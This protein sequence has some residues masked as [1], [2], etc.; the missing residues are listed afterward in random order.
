VRWT[1][2][3]GLYRELRPHLERAVEWIDRD[4]D[5]DGDG[6]T[7][8]ATR[9]AKGF[10]N[11]GWKDSGNSIVNRDGSLAEP[12]I[13]LVEV[14]GYVYR[15][16]RGLAGVARACGD[17]DWARRLAADAHALRQ[18]FRDAF[19][20]ADRN[21]LSLALQKDGEPATAIASN[22]GQAVWSGIVDG[23]QAHAVADRLMSDQLFS[24][25]GI[26]TL[27]SGE[28][29]YNPIDYQVGAVW[30][31]DTALIMAGLKRIGRN[32]DA[33]RLFTGLFEAAALFPHYRLPEVFAGFGRDR[34]PVP[35]RYPVAC[36]P[37]AWAAGAI[38]CM[39]ASALGLE[40]HALH[41]RLQ[42]KSPSLPSW[43]AEVTVRA[44]RVG[45]A[46][47]DLRYHRVGEDTL[48]AVLDRQGDLDVVVTY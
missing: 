29:A 43:L 32:A 46:T 10:R 34:Y 20:A 9:S 16:K 5:S 15:A 38:P 36:S 11:Q 21:Y 7:D 42:I 47:V 27:S 35:V 14:Q 39:L 48:V 41:Q 26:R 23:D 37:Q 18:H 17:D 33:G 25:W 40:P 3:L 45:Q 24:G 44:L 19:W 13:A 6:F 4:G 22:P 28:V 30:P 8:Y 2:D 12:P 1:G 31:H